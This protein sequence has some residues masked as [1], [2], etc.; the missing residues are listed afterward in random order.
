KMNV[1]DALDFSHGQL[2]R[3]IQKNHV[4]G[5]DEPDQRDRE[6]DR[7]RKDLLHT[8]VSCRWSVVRSPANRPRWFASACR[9]WIIDRAGGFYT[10][11]N[12]QRTTDSLLKHIFKQQERD[13][14]VDHADARHPK[15]PGRDV[16]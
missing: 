11:D 13:H 8:N 12:G 5:H 3:C 7:G 15:E 6:M 4:E 2:A 16:P 9:S 1:K 14:C 10:T